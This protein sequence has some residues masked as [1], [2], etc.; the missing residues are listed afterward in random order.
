[1]SRRFGAPKLSHDIPFHSPRLRL[2]RDKLDT[3]AR[4][5]RD[6]P[7]GMPREKLAYWNVG[8]KTARNR[9]Q[10]STACRNSI[11]SSRTFDAHDKGIAITK[12]TDGHIACRH[13]ADSF[14]RSNSSHFSQSRL[15]RITV[16]N[17]TIHNQFL[18]LRDRRKFLMRCIIASTLV[19]SKGE[20]LQTA[21]ESAAS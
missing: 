9:I 12:R 18:Q 20:A 8:L 5:S 10:K 15:Y 2:L 11:S 17:N 7:V 21:F 6:I 16:H 19:K 14:I 1:M 3:S 4:R 13:C